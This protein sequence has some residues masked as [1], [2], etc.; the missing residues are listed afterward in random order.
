M[1]WIDSIAYTHTWVSIDLALIYFPIPNVITDMK[2]YLILGI[3]WFT[4]YIW[5]GGVVIL[6]LPVF[7]ILFMRLRVFFG[8]ASF[9]VLVRIFWFD[10]IFL[11][12]AHVSST[13]MHLFLRVSFVEC[14]SCEFWSRNLVLIETWVVPYFDIEVIFMLAKFHTPVRYE[15]LAFRTLHALYIVVENLW[16]MLDT[17]LMEK[18]FTVSG[19]LKGCYL[20]SDCEFYESGHG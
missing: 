3:M 6:F 1:C 14:M 16:F 8:W 10:W 2:S 17:C 20:L 4:L 5:G 18:E 9:M 11:P 7:G 19:G 15:L 13:C 12:H